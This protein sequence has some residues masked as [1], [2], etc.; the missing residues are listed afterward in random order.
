MSNSERLCLQQPYL[1]LRLRKI[2]NFCCSMRFLSAFRS[3]RA[4]DETPPTSLLAATD[5]GNREPTI[6]LLLA[7]PTMLVSLSRRCRLACG[8]D[9]EASMIFVVLEA[10]L[11]LAEVD[12]KVAGSAA[13]A[14]VAAVASV[15][16][17]C[18]GKG[19]SGTGSCALGSCFCCGYC[20]GCCLLLLATPF[21]WGGW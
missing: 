2:C 4:V 9:T 8:G 10:E 1:S 21:P 3:C 18:G 20:C 12:W 14:G 13:A 11:E 19:D 15:V 7:L 6:L 17:C 16:C 5:A